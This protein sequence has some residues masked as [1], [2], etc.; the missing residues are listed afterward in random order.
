MALRTRLLVILLSAVVLGV[1]INLVRRKKLR[2][3]YALMWLLTAIVLVIT[4][5]S[6]DLLDAI[7]FAIGVDYPPGLLF[8]IAFIGVLF[9]LF[10][11]SLVISKFTDQIKNLSQDVALLERRVRDLEEQLGRPVAGEGSS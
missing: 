4:P 11:F 8:L 5:I 2:E 1:V 6:I 7:A 10:Q 3:E 9:I